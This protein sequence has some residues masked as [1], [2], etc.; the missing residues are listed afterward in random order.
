LMMSAI[1][2]ALRYYSPSQTVLRSATKDVT[3]SGQTIPAGAR[4][5]PILTSANR[6]E[7]KFAEAD[8]FDITRQQNQH[9]AFGNGIHY[10]LGAPLARLEAR[11]AFE[12]ML[13]RLPNLELDADAALAV[14]PGVLINSLKAL[15]LH[16]TPGRPL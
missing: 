9:I 1:E 3:L 5:M 2:E 10:C 16:F 8:R 11:I 15:P 13:E 6:D 12:V 4:V 14:N 7:T